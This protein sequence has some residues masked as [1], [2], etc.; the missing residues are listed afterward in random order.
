MT[1]FRNQGGVSSKNAQMR[2]TLKE[3]V[4]NTLIGVFSGLAI[5]FGQYWLVDI[6]TE[7]AVPAS[8]ACAVAVFGLLF[9]S[10]KEPS[11]TNDT[12]GILQQQ[13]IDTNDGSKISGTLLQNNIIENLKITINYNAIQQPEQS[14]SPPPSGSISFR[15]VEPPEP[16]LTPTDTRVVPSHVDDA[17]QQISRRIKE[18]L[19]HLH[20][21]QFEEAR[22]QLFEILADIKKEPGLERERARVFNNLGVSYNQP[23]EHGDVELAKK[24]FH[25]A[26]DQDS[27]FYLA[28]LNLGLANIEEDSKKS[29]QRGYN[30]IS[31]IWESL[32]NN[33][34]LSATEL[35]PPL[36]AMVWATYRLRGSQA[37]V[38]LIDGFD[39][40]L[41]Q[42]ASKVLP[43]VRLSVSMR[44]ETG[45]LTTALQDCDKALQDTPE[46]PELLSIK[47]RILLQT[48]VKDEGDIKNLALVPEI[49]DKSNVENA[50]KLF[51]E[52]ER[53][54]TDQNKPYLM[55]EIHLGIVQCQLLLGKFLE[56]PATLSLIDSAE[57]PPELAQ[58]LNLLK[59]TTQLQNR[60]FDSALTTLID[61]PG[62]GAISYPEKKLL[63]KRFLYKGAPEQTRRILI[64]LEEEANANKDVDYWLD[65][66]LINVFLDR[67]TEAISAANH[68][69]RFADESN[70]SASVRQE[71]LSNYSAIIFRYVRQV[72]KDEAGRLL[73]SLLA[74]QKEFP[75][76]NIVF[77][78]KA[79]DEHGQLTDE[80]KKMFTDQERARVRMRESFKRSPVPTYVLVHHTNST[81]PDFVCN[82][83]DPEFTIDMTLPDAAFVGNLISTFEGSDTILLDYLS[84][85]D[86]SK[87]DLLGFL[88]R[89]GKRV[90][91]HEKLFHTI[92]DD[93]LIHEIP[94]LRRLWEF[95]R[96]S[97]RVEIIH[98]VSEATF[99][100]GDISPF[101]SDWLVETLKYAKANGT[102]LVTDDLRLLMFLQSENVQVV[103][104]YSLIDHLMKA[105]HLDKRAYSA[106]LGR[107]AERFF[108]FLSFDHEDL[109]EIVAADDYRITP[110]SYHL[111][112]QLLL[113]GSN[114]SSFSIVFARYIR[115]LWGA[116]ILTKDKLHW[117][118]FL[119]RKILEVAERVFNED[120]NADLSPFTNGAESMWREAIDHG[121]KDDLQALLPR[122]DEIVDKEKLRNIGESFRLRIRG[123]LDKMTN[124]SR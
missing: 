112:N 97:N 106:V 64:D 110:R 44:A 71:I 95:L 119:T 117:L 78:V 17:K 120:V 33:T 48:T 104:I 18:A 6:P 50:L 25:Q 96:K 100:V 115:I 49:Q 82:R 27:S 58:H 21:R 74:F 40:R 57:L 37:G 9:R 42:A 111:C 31:A 12:K 105:G 52:A 107:L 39:E 11:A 102:T 5:F 77:P 79:L 51:R 80:I 55:P 89:C 1:A 76:Q 86:L 73:P 26:L 70:L 23:D 8:I 19:E 118:E 92:Q 22:T 69:K 81:Y 2:F 72:G 91:V 83:H 90:L 113:P 63:A 109:A 60:E 34:E 32:K 56:A 123:R 87:S 101:M 24:F 98:D 67:K 66:A 124:R 45:D 85:L 65:V 20:S 46:D 116:D 54:A 62:F 68:A 43:V 75:E 84:L 13:S 7:F 36:S 121:S 88:E 35:E 61:D 114:W 93:L 30:A 47:A 29:I 94:E 15:Q 28:K 4:R 59:F 16:T 122:I 3:S 53:L 108:V 99:T 103:N 41:T 10:S 14:P 38:D